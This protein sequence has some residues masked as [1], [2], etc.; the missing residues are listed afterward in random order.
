MN[1][2]INEFVIA[3]EAKLT[4]PESWEQTSFL[5]TTMSRRR[6]QSLRI[7]PLSEEC[8][9]KLY[10]YGQRRASAQ[11]SDLSANME[12]T[13]NSFEGSELR[14][15]PLPMLPITIDSK[16]PREDVDSGEQRQWI[17]K[18]A[19]RYLMSWMRTVLETNI[20]HFAEP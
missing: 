17:S 15:Q 11:N 1:F 18:K 9:S 13:L 6:N 10:K 8:K 3:R 16:R 2:E 14:A 5:P 12:S 20:E 7:N 19:R 4:F